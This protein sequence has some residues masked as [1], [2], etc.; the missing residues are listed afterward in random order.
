MLAAKSGAGGCD[1]Q[2][3]RPPGLPADAVNTEA[4]ITI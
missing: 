1:E 4:Q 3:V 2:Y